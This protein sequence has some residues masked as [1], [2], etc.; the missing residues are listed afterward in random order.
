ML[1]RSLAVSCQLSAISQREEQIALLRGR[2]LGGAWSGAALRSH[3]VASPGRTRRV[4]SAALLAAAS[5]ACG[6][7]AT[8]PRPGQPSLRVEP[9]TILLGSRLS[10]QH[11]LV[12]EVIGERE[13]DRTDEAQVA[14]EDAGVVVVR[15]GAVLEPI[16]NGVTSIT[17]RVGDRTTKVP[18]TV[19]LEQCDQPPAFR[20]QIEPILSK[21]GCNLGSCYG[22]FAGKGGL[23]LSLFNSEVY[24]DYAAL[25]DPERRR[26]DRARPEESVLLRKVLGDAGHGG[27]ARLARDSLGYKTLLGWVSSGAPL[28]P[29]TETGIDHIEVSPAERVLTPVESGTGPG[30][31]ARPPR[32]GSSS[33]KSQTK[34]A[35]ASTHLLVTAVYAD[36]RRA[37]VTTTALYTSKDPGVAEVDDAG[38]VSA[39]RPGET[40]IVVGYLGHFG[41]SYVLAPL[42]GKSSTQPSPPVRTLVD[43][44]V[45]A[46][47]Q[48]LNVTPAPICDDA[49]LSLIH[50]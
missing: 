32:D 2:V 10:R 42:P 35:A 5:T 19:R 8:V 24:R 48:K 4:L 50:I 49:T 18:V 20:T 6:A 45:F 39:R 31:N 27:G 11:L 43:E 12:T 15:S 37:D 13:I 1:F 3:P 23:R 22:A 41:A 30:A 16:G 40:A 26:I 47:L 14:A 29:A 33:S 46:R 7:G 38:V 9:A 34:L 17:V 28:E 21:A 25:T 44:H 36:G